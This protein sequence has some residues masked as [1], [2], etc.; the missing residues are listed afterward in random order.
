VKSYFDCFPDGAKKTWVVH[1]FNVA[2][3]FAGVGDHPLLYLQLSAD[4]DSGQQIRQGMQ[5][6]AAFKQRSCK[7]IKS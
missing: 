3:A 1:P 7:L 6:M 4:D 2:S 5:T